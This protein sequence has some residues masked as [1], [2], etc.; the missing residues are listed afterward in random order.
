MSLARMWGRVLLPRIVTYDMSIN[1]VIR[2][3]RGLG[4]ATWRYQDM[5]NDINEFL[6]RVKYEG[7]LRVLKPT[8][9]PPTHLMTEVTLKR[10]RSYMIKGEAEWVD[11]RTGERQTSYVSMYRD[12]IDTA[13]QME[14]EFDDYQRE[15]GYDPKW[16]FLKLNLTQVFHFE[17]QPY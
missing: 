9:V 6:G 4:Y 12:T 3:V 7:S 14:A 13:Q 1:A 10:P 17:G 5:R 15:K 8:S 11:W 16:A 2:H